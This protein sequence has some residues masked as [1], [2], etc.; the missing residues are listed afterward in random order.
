ME[1]NFE[2]ARIDFS[3]SKL[4]YA[5]SFYNGRGDSGLGFFATL[6]KTKA[7]IKSHKTERPAKKWPYVVIWLLAV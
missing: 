5:I 2:V 3:I 4:N 7:R 6:S 1:K